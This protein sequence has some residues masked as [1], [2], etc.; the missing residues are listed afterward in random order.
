M[1]AYTEDEL[2]DQLKNQEYKYGF[3]TDIDSEVIPKGLN[4]AVIRLISSKKN[5]PDWLLDFRLKAFAQWQ[6]MAEKK[7]A[8][9]NYP[10][11]A[12]QSDGFIEQG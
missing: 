7:W 5:E 10:A 1:A 2:E 12:F 4:E 3:T 9:V 8:H 11:V 6:E